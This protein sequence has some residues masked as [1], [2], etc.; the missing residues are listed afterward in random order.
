MPR[1]HRINRITAT[2][3]SILIAFCFASLGEAGEVRFPLQN[4][5]PWQSNFESGENPISNAFPVH[6]LQRKP[7]YGLS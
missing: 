1:A 6:L 2:V 7:A 4:C 3:Q 5:R